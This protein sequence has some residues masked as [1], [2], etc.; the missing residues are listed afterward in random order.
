MCLYGHDITVAQTPVSAALGWIVGKE[1]RDPNS[2]SSK[3][4]GSSVILSQLSSPATT[5]KERRIGLTVEPG[6]PAREGAPIVDLADGTTQ[7]GV[8]TSGLPSPTLGGTN[9]AMG[10]IK[11][12]LHKKGTEV[13]VLVRKK[14]RKATVTP[15]P[16]VPSKFYRG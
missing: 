13:G 5:L 9:I 14:L 4:N 1:R 15:M 3:F 16:W 10:Y 2:P 7:I 8:V 11:Q 6:A 12:G